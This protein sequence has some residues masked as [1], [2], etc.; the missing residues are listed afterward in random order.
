VISSTDVDAAIYASGPWT[1]RDIAANGARFH[2]AE[3]GTGPVALF[4]HGFPTYWWTWREHLERFAAA[5]Y[6]AVAMDLRGYGGSDHPPEGYDLP[7]LTNDVD[8]VL[9]S[10]GIDDAVVIGHGWGGLIAWSLAAMHPD[11][12]RA[13]VPISAPHPRTMR[14]W[15][16]A[17]HLGVLRQ[18]MSWQLP[19][20][21]ERAL[22]ARDGARI[23]HM[24]HAWSATPGW[25]DAHASMMYRSAFCR[26]PTAHTAIEYQRWAVRSLIRKDGRRY[27]DAMNVPIPIPVL[28]LHGEHDPVVPANACRGSATYVP[29]NYTFQLMPGGHFTHEESSDFVCGAILDWLADL[30]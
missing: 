11:V 21:P 13:I 12:V 25:P 1:H 17:R 9:R 19:F 4:L 20:W 27:M 7:T 28:H 30:P 3:L 24:L 29:G 22:Q 18:T 23:D 10:L 14:Q 6:R 5:G 2:I 8:S 26:W 16:T 15:Q